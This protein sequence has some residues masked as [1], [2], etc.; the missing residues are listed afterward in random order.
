MIVLQAFGTSCPKAM[1]KEEKATLWMDGWE[2]EGHTKRQ[3]CRSTPHRGQKHKPS[4]LDEVSGATMP[5]R[6]WNL[7]LMDF[8]CF[9]FKQQDSKRAWKGIEEEDEEGFEGCKS[10][11][12]AISTS[13][14]SDSLFEDRPISRSLDLTLESLSST[15][16]ISMWYWIRECQIKG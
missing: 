7:F 9:V 1:L 15:M 10:F 4:R 2:S 11:D 12:T 3:L 16:A 6:N 13:F 14:S 8:S 5:C